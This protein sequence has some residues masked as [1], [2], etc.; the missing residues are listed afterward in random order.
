MNTSEITKRPTSEITLENQLL[1][2][3][4]LKKLGL[5]ERITYMHKLIEHAGEEP[6]I[7]EQLFFGRKGEAKAIQDQKIAFSRGITQVLNSLCNSLTISVKQEEGLLGTKFCAAEIGTAEVLI[8]NLNQINERAITLLVDDYLEA[9]ASI[10]EKSEKLGN[11]LKELLLSEAKDRLTVRQHET[12]V[13]F[14]QLLSQFRSLIDN[15][16]VAINER[17]N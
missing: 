15:F 7:I 6:N 1:S 10:E 12:Y 17:K 3:Q 8:R 14:K 4:Q 2:E 11:E 13:G 5:E 16:V 9:K